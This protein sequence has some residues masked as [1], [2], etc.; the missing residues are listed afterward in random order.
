M[1]TPEIAARCDA[2]PSGKGK[3]MARCPAHDDR[4]PS[5]AIAEGRD[6]RVL[7]RCF[8]GCPIESVVSAIGIGMQDLF[9]EHDCAPKAT[10][11]KARPSA[12]DAR[13][14]LVIAAE[15]Y[16]EQYGIEGLL[17]TSEINVIR[18]TVARS[19]H[20]MELEPVQRPLWEGA[21]GGRDRDPAWPAIFEWAMM[22][23]SIQLLGAP[24][25]FDESL[26]PPKAILL[27]AEDTAASAM[28]SL[29]HEPRR[30]LTEG[31]P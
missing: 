9:V 18:A 11:Q 25:A 5:L 29:E 2:K 6:G 12:A 31:A 19:H 21:Y 13:R 20:G 27:E 28:H 4:R 1:T 8:A 17:R 22:I 7:L 23:A 24:L 3:W 14:A 30:C 16:R 10:R 15:R 26:P